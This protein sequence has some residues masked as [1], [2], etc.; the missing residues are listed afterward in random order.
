M[1]SY[2]QISLL[3]DF[4]FCPRSI[5]FHGLYGKKSTKFYHTYYQTKGL[6]AHRTIDTKT[7]TTAKNI[8][9]GLDVYSEKYN[10]CG[11][12]DVYDASKK[13]LTE[14]KKKIKLIYDGY[15]FQLYAQYFC[16]TEMGYPVD[17][18]RFYSM[19][20]NKVYPIELPENQPEKFN[21]FEN[22][23]KQIQCFDLTA[24][25]DPNPNKCQNCIYNPMCDYAL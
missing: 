23:I 8:F 6:N 17:E 21:E 25:F 2:I 11:K 5:Y 18:I 9:Q 15:I 16:L 20:D 22:I 12:I 3:N 19:D 7:Y 10:L 13:L 1:E 14:R 24:R 4:V